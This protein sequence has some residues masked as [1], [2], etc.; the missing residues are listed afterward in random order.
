MHLPWGWRVELF[1]PQQHLRQLKYLW[2]QQE[3]LSGRRIQ[4]L[5]PEGDS[6]VQ[7][8]GKESMGFLNS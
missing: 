7:G 2:D 1:E 5:F 3:G 4:L 6:G 8:Q